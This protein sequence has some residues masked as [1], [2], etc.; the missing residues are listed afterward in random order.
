MIHVTSPAEYP[1]PGGLALSL[2]AAD[3]ARRPESVQEEY[4]WAGFEREPGWEPHAT[5]GV[6][7]RGAAAGRASGPTGRLRGAAP[8]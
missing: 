8:I 6:P 3:R 5:C 4:F 7:E 1:V 2:V